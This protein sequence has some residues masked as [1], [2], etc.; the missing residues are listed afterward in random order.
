MIQPYPLQKLKRTKSGNLSGKKNDNL[1]PPY[2]IP[3]RLW[4]TSLDC[5]VMT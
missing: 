2:L 4:S 5:E 3:E 1:K